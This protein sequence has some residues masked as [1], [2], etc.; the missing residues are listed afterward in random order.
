LIS[1]GRKGIKKVMKKGERVSGSTKRKKLTGFFGGESGAA[2]IMR[3]EM[4][5]S[6]EKQHWISLKG[7]GKLCRMGK[8]KGG[9]LN[10]VALIQGD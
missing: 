6:K 8:K 2:F 1:D 4:K 5:R 10:E 7:E 3:L 9:G